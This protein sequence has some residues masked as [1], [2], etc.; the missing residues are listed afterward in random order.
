MEHKF[1]DHTKCGFYDL[2][3]SQRTEFIK[4]NVT[5][6]GVLF[7]LLPLLIAPFA[8]EYKA[9]MIVTFLLA[10]V[11]VTVVMKENLNRFH[12]EQYD[13]RSV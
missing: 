10:L 11:G 1:F 4:Q 12:R 5:A 6:F 8:G 3:E 7:V 2:S 9:A 13:K